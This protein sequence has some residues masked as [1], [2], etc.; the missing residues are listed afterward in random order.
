MEW[1]FLILIIAFVSWSV[2]ILAVYRRLREKI[3][4][5]VE[6]AQASQAET[7]AQAQKYEIR[8][9][10]LAQELADL[11]GTMDGLEKTEM[12]LEQEVADFR[13]QDA[14]RRPTRHRVEPDQ[15]AE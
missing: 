10:E 5:Q 3:N 9:E 13:H 6:T 15:N 7:L 14:Q 1:V 11:K 4:A 12:R 2:Q 8:A